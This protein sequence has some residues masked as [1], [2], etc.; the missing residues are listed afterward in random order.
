MSE[1]ATSN[2]RK[3]ERY[4]MDED[5]ISGN[6]TDIVFHDSTDLLRDLEEYERQRDGTVETIQSVSDNTIGTGLVTSS[7][8]TDTGNTVT[9]SDTTTNTTNT[10]LDI[11]ICVICTERLDD[12]TMTFSCMHR[13]HNECLSYMTSTNCPLCRKDIADELSEELYEEICENISEFRQQTIEEETNAIRRDLFQQSRSG[14]GYDIEFGRGISRRLGIAHRVSS[15]SL[16]NI[17]DDTE[18]SLSTRLS[19]P[20]IPFNNIDNTRV[21]WASNI[22]RHLLFTLDFNTDNTRVSQAGNI[23]RLLPLT[24]DY[25]NYDPVDLDMEDYNDEE[26][27]NEEENDEE[28][29]GYYAA[30]L[31]SWTRSALISEYEEDPYD[32]DNPNGI[33]ERY[34]DR[35]YM[36][37][38][39]YTSEDDD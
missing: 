33:E 26:Y 29:M 39:Y 7:G 32:E 28:D 21:A 12:K 4:D 31:S 16:P 23:G 8:N 34:M 15:L 1:E 5:A 24:D 13:F 36:D 17:P 38:E 25:N 14:I 18:Q 3:R 10:T 2:S 35:E 11:D 6:R 27:M 9:T 22:G 30:P 20:S 19:I 37:S